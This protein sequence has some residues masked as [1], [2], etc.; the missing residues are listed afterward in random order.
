[1]LIDKKIFG[2]GI[3]L[4]ILGSIILIFLNSTMPVGHKEMT[5]EEVLDLTLKQ[6]ENQDFKTIAGIL[7]GVGFMLIL[8]SFGARRGKGTPK[9]NLEKPTI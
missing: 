4:L 1:M 5:E 3:C 2:C 9:K 6:Q 7:V 8:I